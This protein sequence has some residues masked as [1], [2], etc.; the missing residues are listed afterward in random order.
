LRGE[1]HFQFAAEQLALELGVLAD[2]GGDHLADLPVLEQHA[3]A[4]A[5]DAAVVGDHGQALDA[6]ALDFGDEVLGDAAQAK[7]AGQHGHVVGQARQGLFVSC[8]TLVQ[9]GHAQSPFVVVGT[10][11]SSSL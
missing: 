6:A 11:R 4:K 7:A 1:L 2:V 9:S 5:V 8:Y 10:V 3:Q